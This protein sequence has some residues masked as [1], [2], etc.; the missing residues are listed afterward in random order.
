VAVDERQL[1]SVHHDGQTYEWPAGREALQE[2][3]DGY[4]D[5]VMMN[6][7]SHACGKSVVVHSPKA[8]H[9]HLPVPRS[10]SAAKL[11]SGHHHHSRFHYTDSTCATTIIWLGLLSELH[12]RVCCECVQQV[13][14]V[15]ACSE[16]V[17]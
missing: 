17:Q 9:A 1:G 12:Q 14:A 3:I 2:A 6:C 11:D 15:S 13:R 16:R 10:A 5:L 4:P 7:W 8:H